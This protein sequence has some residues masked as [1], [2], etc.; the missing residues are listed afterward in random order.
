MYWP[1]HPGVRQTQDFPSQSRT[2]YDKVARSKPRL[3]LEN[4]DGQ[5]SA[6]TLSSSLYD[7]FLDSLIRQNCRAHWRDACGEDDHKYRATFTENHRTSAQCG[8]RI[9]QRPYDQIAPSQEMHQLHATCARPELSSAVLPGRISQQGNVSVSLLPRDQDVS[10]IK[11]S[12]SP[13]K[14]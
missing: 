12:D 4:R 3:F 7:Q 1:D 2:R 14:K 13:S 8:N 11:R 5:G 6:C 9:N 10:G